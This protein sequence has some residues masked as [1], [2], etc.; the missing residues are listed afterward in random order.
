MAARI[1]GSGVR[2]VAQACLNYGQR[3]QFSL[4]ECTVGEAELVRLRHDLLREI[5]AKEDSLR[6][7]FLTEDARQR[8]EHHGLKPSQDFEDALVI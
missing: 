6:L 2:R 5:N 3:V 7:Y 1:V 8:V 4:F